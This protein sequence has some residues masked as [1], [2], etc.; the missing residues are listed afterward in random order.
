MI[1]EVLRSEYLK[2]YKTFCRL[3]DEGGVPERLVKKLLSLDKKVEA[4]ERGCLGE[5]E[6]LRLEAEKCLQRRSSKK[7]NPKPLENTKTQNRG[8]LVSERA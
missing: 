6:K 4:R 8:I 3:H 5:V 7:Q 1:L 2:M